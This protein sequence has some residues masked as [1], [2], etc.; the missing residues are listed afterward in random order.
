MAD[1]DAT[2]DLPLPGS[3]KWEECEPIDAGW[4]PEDVFARATILMERAG[5][6]LEPR[7]AEW[8][9]RHWHGSYD[10][11]VVKWGELFAPVCY[12]TTRGA[13]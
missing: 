10:I 11:Y 3:V 7:A 1:S 6:K 9:W 8:R 5:A 2:E 4:V 13:W 12:S